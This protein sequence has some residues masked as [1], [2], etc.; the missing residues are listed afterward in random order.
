MSQL[1]NYYYKKAMSPFDK[2]YEGKIISEM[3]QVR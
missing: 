1:L 2:S 3:G